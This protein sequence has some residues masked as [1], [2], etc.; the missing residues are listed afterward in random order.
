MIKKKC[1]RN[2]FNIKK[3]NTHKPGHTKETFWDNNILT[4]H[5]MYNYFTILEIFKLNWFELP[6][7][8]YDLLHLNSSKN[9]LYIPLLKLNHYQQNFLYQGPNLW[10]LLTSKYSEFLS[11]LSP[12]I[13]KRQLKRFLI[14]M[15]SYGDNET[16]IKPKK[17]LES[18]LS[19]IANDPYY[20]YNQ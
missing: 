4:I 5:N 14:N 18:F 1:L 11:Y 17:N 15:Q 2:L 13:F 19:T 6:T 8:L 12:K 16:W 10:N 3:V 7:Y 20:K 9:R